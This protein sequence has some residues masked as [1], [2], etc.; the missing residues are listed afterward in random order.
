MVLRFCANLS[1]LF[2]IAPL[3]LDRYQLAKDAGFKGVESAFPTNV[4]LN[5][6]VRVQQQTGLQQIL[7]NMDTGNILNGEFGCASFLNSANDFASVLNNTI[8]YAKALNCQKIHI[9]AGRHTGPT[10]SR[11]EQ[12]FISNLQYASNRLAQEG[13]LGVIEPINKYTIEGYYLNSF[14]Q[15]VRV[16]K[17][18][19]H[20]N[21]KLMLDFYHL[22]HIKGDITKSMEELAQYIGHVQ[23]AQTPNRAEP[24]TWGEVNLK[25]ALNVLDEQIGY[26][27]WIGCEYRPLAGT[28]EGLK[29]ITD[30]GYEL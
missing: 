15:A 21:L 30:F 14:E 29:W 18:V 25:Y 4:N 19:N 16:I 22:Q 6:L 13:I 9:L 28:E 27:G 11:H 5:D 8:T 7:L 12:A 24:D 23:V 17:A 3:L 20:P 10:D 1:F 2:Q 26:D